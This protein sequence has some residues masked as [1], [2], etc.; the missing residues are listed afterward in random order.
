MITV[1]VDDR[2]AMARFGPSGIPESVRKNL[3]AII[4]NLT[5][6]L[7]ALVDANLTGGLKTRRRLQ[8]K[9]EMVENPSALY[10]RVRTI[11]T[12]EPFFLPNILETGAKAH[13]IRGI[14]RPDKLLF[15][16]IGGHL[17]SKHEVNHPGFPGIHYAGNALAAMES[18][19]INGITQAVRNGLGPR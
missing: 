17:I 15:F 2:A 4:P 14:N 12:S 11:S 1:K 5:K 19:I 9:S 7:G 18:E 13:I 6:R 10:G 8:V 3:R 16:E